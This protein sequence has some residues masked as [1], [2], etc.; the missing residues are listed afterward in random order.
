MAN[1]VT[2][3]ASLAYDDGKLSKSVSITDVVKSIAGATARYTETVQLVGTAEEAIDLGEVS[4]PGFAL[5]QNLD[6]TNYIELRVATGGA[7]FAKLRADTN[8]DGHGGFAI[9]ELGSG[10]QAPFAIAN[11]DP[12]RMRVFIV[13]A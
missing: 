1:E 12:C 7:K 11:T 3:G 8:D 6:D 2:L 10:A 13:E 4:A 9:L 5:F